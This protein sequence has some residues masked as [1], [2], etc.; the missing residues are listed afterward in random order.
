ML[1]QPTLQKIHI[2]AVISAHGFGHAARAAAVLESLRATSDSLH[3]DIFSETP[4]WF[5]AESLGSGFSF[6]AI[7]VDVGIVQRSPFEEDLP[8][9]R[10]KLEKMYLTGTQIPDQLA[11]LFLRAECRLVLCDISPA[12]ILAASNAG[13]PSVLVENFTWDWIYSGYFGQEPG[14]IA[15]AQRLQSIFAKADYHIQAEPICKP[16][17]CDLA[18]R[19]VARRPRNSRESTRKRLGVP[20][21]AK[22]VLI[23]AGGIEQRYPALDA[24]ASAP[25]NVQFVIPGGS[26]DVLR[27][28]NVT[29]LPHHSEFFHP[30]LVYASDAVLGKLGYSTIAEAYHAGIPFAFAPRENFRE[31]DPLARF[32]RNQLGGIEVSYQDFASG[33]WIKILPELLACPRQERNCP[34]GADEIAGFVL[35]TILGQP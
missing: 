2:A 25:A 8:Q 12:G 24:L 4:E 14:L 6:H 26:D 18:S 22:L 30:D 19:P 5:F 9:T 17:R 35:H 7:P 23:T 21:D 1:D 34:N 11:E 27:A 20:A 29:L 33:N 31:T 10:E 15:A 13:I 28:G 16:R 32:V 3:F